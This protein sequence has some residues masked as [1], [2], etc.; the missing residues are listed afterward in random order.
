[1]YDAYVRSIN[2]PTR[3]TAFTQSGHSN[4]V[5]IGNLTG[6]KRPEWVGHHAII[7][8]IKFTGSISGKNEIKYFLGY[9]GKSAVYQLTD[10]E[11]N[12]MERYLPDDFKRD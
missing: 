8:R 7:F 11:Y 10:Q 9:K 12:E 4:I 2:R 5:D 3:L 1:L 6:R